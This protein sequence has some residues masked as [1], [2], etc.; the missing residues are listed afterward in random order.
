[1]PPLLFAKDLESRL[2]KSEQRS[3]INM[4]ELTFARKQQPART[5]YPI[6]LSALT[7]ESLKAYARS[8]RSYMSQTELDVANLAFTL[9]ERRKRHPVAWMTTAS[10]I[11][12]LQG[13]ISTDISA[14]STPPSFKKVVLAFAGQSK[15][16]IGLSK[17]LYEANPRL[18]HY[19][20]ECDHILKTL[21]FPSI[22]SAIFQRAS[23][24]DPVLL[25]TGTMAVQYASAKCWIDAG[26]QPACTIGHS[27]GELTALAISGVL[28]IQDALRVV[29][30]RAQLMATKWGPEK[31]TMLAVFA[32]VS[33]V[34]RIIEVVKE[35]TLEIA[36]FN[37]TNS[38]IV[39]GTENEV[40]DVE[41]LLALDRSF[42]GVRSQRV[43]VTHGFH[44]TF[45]EPLRDEFSNSLKALAFRE[46]SIPIEPCTRERTE[47]ITAEHVVSHLREPVY[48]MNA[49]QR[50]EERLG[51][52]IWLEAGFD[53]P[54]IPMIKRATANPE[55]QSFLAIKTAGMEQPVEAITKVTIDLWKQGLDV[56]PWS[57]LSPSE[58]GLE[59]IWLPP[60]QFQKTKAWLEN[61]DR[62]TEIQQ[63]FAN[64][65]PK[66]SDLTPLHLPVR[67]LHHAGSNGD[68]EKFLINKS[69]SRFREVIDGHAVRG[70]PLC[71]A[72]MY[73]E[74]VAMAAQL[75]GVDFDS[76]SMLFED[77]AFSVHRDNRHPQSRLRLRA[78]QYQDCLHKAHQ[79]LV[80]VH[81]AIGQS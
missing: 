4:T 42:D 50:I 63:N 78:R 27:F 24:E 9:S 48:F 14:Y 56:T 65:G 79:L 32:P 61:I 28:S 59:P 19:I 39:V 26:I 10:D 22:I 23:I 5:A 15:Q 66:K 57:F 76:N 8:L 46:A 72:S 53:S 44:S 70:R 41:K 35:D 2:A 75:V 1:M 62:A 12:S 51:G 77:L 80:V 38:Q 20:D 6:I 11:A 3:H 17:S 37:A 7:V 18:R 34:K 71:P 81:T 73:M 30:T 29:A 13:E 67:L 45:T 49:V 58:T 47:T 40:M 69:A 33:V 68:K 31:G 25:Q 60:Y 54:I 16:T 52:C 55:V 43:D 21:G 36:C 74:C 64:L